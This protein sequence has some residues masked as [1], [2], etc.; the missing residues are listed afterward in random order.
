MLQVENCDPRGFTPVLAR[1][2]ESSAFENTLATCVLK[3]MLMAVQSHVS[4]KGQ[5]NQQRRKTNPNW[6][7]DQSQNNKDK[8]VTL[9]AK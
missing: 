6:G 7:N 3:L 5:A 4:E 8:T 1:P 2:K 9:P